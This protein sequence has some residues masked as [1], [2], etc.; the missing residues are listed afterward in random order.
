MSLAKP[1]ILRV[2]DLHY[3]HRAW[4]ELEKHA[5]VLV[6][7]LSTR[8]QFLQDLKGKYSQVQYITNTIGSADRIG[9][10]DK[11]LIQHLPDSLKTISHCGAGYDQIDPVA[12]AERGIQLSNVPEKVNDATADTHVFLLLGAL[13]NFNHGH[14]GLLEG[15]WPGGKSAGAP[16]AHDPK[17]KVVGIVGLG[18]IGRNILKKLKPFGFEK[19][20]YHNRNKLSS[21]LEDGAEYVSF[22]ELLSTSDIIS[23]NIPLNPNT[24]HFFNDEVFAK[25]KKGM[26]LVNTA[27]G[28]VIDESALMRALD[29]GTVRSAGL[30]VLE[31]EPNVNLDLCRLPNVLALPHMGTHTVETVQ[32]MEEYVVE[33]VLHAIKTGK[34]KSLVPEQKGVD[35]KV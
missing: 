7:D 9:L 17:G 24:R 11:E 2:G 32:S 14:Q 35:F 12:L 4:K 10:F 27:R 30:D 19:F 15:K 13:R 26:V 29:N 33:N 21:E 34:V 20:I 25:M 18:G 16:M 28:A 6:A 5:T 22:D 3:A 31:N 8:E 23:I 1:I